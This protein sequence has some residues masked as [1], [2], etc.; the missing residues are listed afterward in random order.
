MGT[1]M[2]FFKAS[3]KY[4]VSALALAI[5]I[6]GSS[7]TFAQT[8]DDTEIIEADEIVVTARKRDE[9]L[10]EVPISIDAFSQDDLNKLGITLSLIHI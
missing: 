9:T 1:K 3:N 10:T 6:G 5:A 7:T 4:C 2:T 8:S